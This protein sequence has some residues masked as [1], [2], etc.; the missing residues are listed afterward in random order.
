MGILDDVAFRP[1]SNFSGSGFFLGSESA[2]VV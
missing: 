1:F 2:G